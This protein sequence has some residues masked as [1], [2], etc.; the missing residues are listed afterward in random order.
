MLTTRQDTNQRV[1][2][3]EAASGRE[4]LEG[5][6]V[7]GATVDACTIFCLFG[8]GGPCGLPVAPLWLLDRS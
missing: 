7:P 8:A 1:E 5:P 2:T 4:W 3:A 6:G